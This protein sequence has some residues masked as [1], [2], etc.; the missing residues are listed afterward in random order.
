ML[1]SHSPKS[2][3]TSTTTNSANPSPNHPYSHK[4]HYPHQYCQEIP[5]KKNELSM[6]T[7]NP[8]EVQDGP[9]VNPELASA[10]I[11]SVI[12]R[13]VVFQCQQCRTIVADSSD[14]LCTDAVNK[15]VVFRDHHR[16][17]SILPE[18]HWS[19]EEYS[20]GSLYQS[21]VCAKC[22]TEIGVRYHTT[23]A[24]IDNLRDMFTLFTGALFL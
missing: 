19:Q 23:N 5:L 15:L 20:F 12:Q 17:I 11:K 9:V 4:S 2:P 18:W 21:L 22:S 8:N 6:S 7:S 10:D 3:V 13:P 16:N 24:N 1:A 14:L